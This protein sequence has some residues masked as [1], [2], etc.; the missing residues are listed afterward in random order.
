MEKYIFDNY[1]LNSCVEC[2]SV[3]RRCVFRIN[4]WP[5]MPDERSG[6]L[7]GESKS[8]H[9]EWPDREQAVGLVVVGVVIVVVVGGV[10]VVVVA[11]EQQRELYF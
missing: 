8:Q 11:W 2:F 9:S 5:L 6:V 1:T 7:I 3:T 4:L 10:I